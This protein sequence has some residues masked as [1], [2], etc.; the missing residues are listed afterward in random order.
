MDYKNIPRGYIVSDNRLYRESNDGA[1]VTSSY[2]MH[3][4]NFLIYPPDGIHSQLKK[5]M[6]NH[7]KNGSRILIPC[8]VQ[9]KADT[10]HVDK[11][12]YWG[13]PLV[14]PDIDKGSKFFVEDLIVPYVFCHETVELRD[15]GEGYILTSEYLGKQEVYT[16]Q[17]MIK[18]GDSIYGKMF[19]AIIRDTNEGKEGKRPFVILLRNQL[20]K[21]TFE[22]NREEFMKRFQR[23][24]LVNEMFWWDI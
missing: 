9:E 11:P 17:K 5:A 12:Y 24:K 14:P 1:Y 16:D 4:T 8:L 7:K 3:S 15:G 23:K 22:Q 19:H 18:N 2:I 20:D 10:K 21:D 6:K 13:L